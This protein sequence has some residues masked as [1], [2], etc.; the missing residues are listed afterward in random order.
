MNTETV[1]SWF[2]CEEDNNILKAYDHVREDIEDVDCVP[3][4]IHVMLVSAALEALKTTEYRFK[5]RKVLMHMRDMLDLQPP[6]YQPSERLVK[7]VGQDG[8]LY[9]YTTYTK[10][11]RDHVGWVPIF[12]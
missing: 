11:E 10:N 12:V 2:F 4:E 8:F 9:I 7:D 1:F 6:K 3:A 5:A